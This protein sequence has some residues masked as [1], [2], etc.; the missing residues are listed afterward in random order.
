MIALPDAF[1]E[2]CRQLGEAIVTR[3]FVERELGEARAELEEAGRRI[4]E[5]TTAPAPDHT[6]ET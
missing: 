2:A 5:L 6:Q 4:V 1:D 3:S